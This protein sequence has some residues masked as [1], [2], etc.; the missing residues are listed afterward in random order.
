MSV[1]STEY[2]DHF[3]FVM[4]VMILKEIIHSEV[5]RI[6][7]KQAERRREKYPRLMAGGYLLSWGVTLWAVLT[8]LPAAFAGFLAAFMWEVLMPPIWNAKK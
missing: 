6:D 1:M 3:A 7:A 8:S 5:Y 4:I 2:F